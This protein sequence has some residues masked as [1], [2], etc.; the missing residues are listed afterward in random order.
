MGTQKT[1]LSFNKDILITFWNK[2]YSTKNTVVAAAGNVE[3]DKLVQLVEKHLNLPQSDKQI[4]S[5]KVNA[6]SMKTFELHQPINQA[7]LCVGNTGIPF[8][9]QMRYPL[10]VLNTYLGGGMSSRLFQKLREK[11]G[12]AYSVYSY[13]DFYKDTGIFGAYIGTD[14]MKFNQAKKMLI[15]ELNVPVQKKLS[16]NTMKKLKNQLKGSIVIGF[17]NT[18]RRMS[19]IAK[20]EIYLNKYV[21]INEII[22]NIDAVTPEDI[23][24][25]AQKVINT[26]NFTGVI[27]HN[28][29]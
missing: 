2:F 11:N 3:H 5:A 19:H 7:H 15:D 9:S 21:D 20:N 18:S 12:L 27:L 4:K 29:N 28:K 13:L 25:V 26:D 10:L 22:S 8:D 14:K 6:P 24:T 23:Y 16:L 1:V 17:E